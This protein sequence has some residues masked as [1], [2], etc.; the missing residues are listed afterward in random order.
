M[1]IAKTYRV[2]AYIDGFNL[3]FGI[4][5]DPQRRRWLWLNVQEM[6]RRFLRQDQALVKTKYFTARIG[7][8][9]DKRKRQNAY[10]D[11][12]G[13]L[14][15]GSFEII[16]GKY[17]YEPFPCHNCG[18]AGISPKEKMTDSNIAVEMM[19]DG[20]ANA[21]DTAIL[22]C[23]DS[24]QKPTISAVHSVWPEKRVV[25]AFP[26][27]RVSDDLRS[28]AAA[29]FVI[30]ESHLRHSQFPNC[31]AVNGRHHVKPFAWK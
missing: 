6:A 19:K 23:G 20:I 24:D 9:E 25:V 22:V 28:V 15:P 13:T 12:L 3:Y 31:F 29:H 17:Q 1:S 26:P 7:G 4:N 27:D 2:I 10:L 5:A 11:A 21:F 16:F 14:D 30:S 8:P 18:Y